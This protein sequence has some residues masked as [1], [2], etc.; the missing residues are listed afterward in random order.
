MTQD[1]S[2]TSDGHGGLTFDLPG[3]SCASVGTVHVALTLDVVPGPT[4][5]TF[6]VPP[7]SGELMYEADSEG[8]T[9]AAKVTVK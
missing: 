3:S 5:G 7:G 1:T 8:Y 2:P 6:T 4:A 9:D